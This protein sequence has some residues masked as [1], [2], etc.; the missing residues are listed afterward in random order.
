[1]T[2]T[3]HLRC[4]HCGQPLTKSLQYRDVIDVEKIEDGQPLV[5]RGFYSDVAGFGTAAENFYDVQEGEFLC[6]VDDL[7]E[8][9]IRPT[10]GCCG[11]DG[12]NGQD[13][14]CR[15][16]HPVG[17][18][19]GDCWQPHFVHLSPNDVVHYDDVCRIGLGG[20]VI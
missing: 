18:I 16:D 9:K 8:M 7:I 17:T 19:V 4:R 12:S 3:I 20:P 14:S 6:N 2:K 13:V 15:N 1:M 11:P 10:S 5:P